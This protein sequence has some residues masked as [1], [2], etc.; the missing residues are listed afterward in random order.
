M[1]TFSPLGRLRALI[2]EQPVLLSSAIRVT[3]LCGT[4]F[5]LDWT[6]E[7][8]AAAMLVIEGWLAVGSWILVTPTVTAAAEEAAA[9]SDALRAV[10]ALG[11][12]SGDEGSPEVPGGALGAA[13]AVSEPIGTDAVAEVRPGAPSPRIGPR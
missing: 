10:D 3:V 4:A 9:V 6:P 13:P 8:I 1:T 2:T 11:A 12:L 7:Q 5:G